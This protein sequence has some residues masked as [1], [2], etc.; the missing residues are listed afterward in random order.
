MNIKA[1]PSLKAL[2][3]SEPRLSWSELGLKKGANGTPLHTLDNACRVLREHPDLA[4]RIWYDEYLQRMLT[5]WTDDGSTVEWVDMFDLRLVIWFQR[6]VRLYKMTTAMAREASTKVA[7]DN[8]RNEVTNWMQRLVWDGMPRLADL[9]PLGFGAQRNSYTQ[10]VGRS[11]VCGM[12]ARALDPGCKVDTMPVF[13]G[14]QGT[15][16]STALHVLVGDR[17]FAES[18]ADP[19]SK[20]FFEALHGK[21]LVEIPELHSF[22]RAEVAAVKRVMSCRTDR[23]RAPYARKAEDHPR[24]GVFAGTTNHNDWNRDDTGARRFLPIAC[25]RIDLSWIETNRA[26][27]FA[28]AVHVFRVD[29]LWWEV[30]EEHAKREQ[31]ARR[32]HDAWDHEIETWLVGRNETGVGDVLEGALRIERRDWTRSN[33]MRVA[34]CLKKLGWTKSDAWRNGG[35]VKIWT[36]G[37]AGG[38][39]DSF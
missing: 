25:G 5:N 1:L 12:A 10:A 18:F 23:F 11:F 26:Q 13:E 39:D 14:A 30:S 4:G 27:L 37:K 24:M 2:L 38:N 20:D 7:F 31:E 35:H 15:G 32:E 21:L 8:R 3:E 36:R 34:A 6:C 22:T 33:Q 28:E 9:I 19:T 16:K 29:P 17:W